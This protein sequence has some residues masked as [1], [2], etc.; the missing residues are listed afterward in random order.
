MS[1]IISFVPALHKG[2]I[3]FFKKYPGTLYLLDADFVTDF[4]RLERDLRQTNADDM[5]KAIGALGIFKEI[6][7]LHV[8]EVGIVKIEGEIVMP[9]EDITRE[10]KDKYF[11]KLEVK[12]EPVFLRWN[13]QI[14]LTESIVPPDRI[15]SIDEFDKEVIEKAFDEASKSS[16][17]WRQVGAV[18][19][20][21]K[22]VLL[23]GYNKHMPS[24]LS[25]DMYGDP[26]SSFDAGERIDLSTAIHGEANLIARA[27]RKGTSL[28][29]ASIYV[30]TFPCPNCAK[31][32]V[33]AGI[34]KVFYSKGYSLLDAETILKT[35]EVEIVL[36]KSE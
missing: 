7:V 9:D 26:R 8:A 11:S 23:A 24:D 1:A 34:K 4:P 30:T 32:I 15:I 36:V 27:A 18:V 6:K 31:L 3:D 17:W 19:V 14:T 10:L 12:F 29:G 5:K 33:E 16:D 22:N 13:R 20:K 21:D 25:M 28:E 2:Y 35:A